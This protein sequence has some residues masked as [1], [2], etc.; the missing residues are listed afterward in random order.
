MAGKVMEQTVSLLGELDPSFQNM[1]DTAADSLADLAKQAKNGEDATKQLERSMSQMGDSTGG[2]NDGFTVMKGI[3][4]NLA[5]QAITAGIDAVKDF[6]RESI[7]AGMEFTSTMS[8][9]QAISGASASE[10]R[11]LEET[12]RMYGATTKFSA[13]EAGE[14][15]TYMAMAG[16]KTTDMTAGLGGIL[17]LA[18]AAGEDL[19]TTSDIVTDGLTAFGLSASESGHFADVM[20]AASSSAN[21]NVSMMGETFKY[22]GAVA[23]AMGISI[24][25][26]SIATGLMAN[27]GIKASSAGTTLRTGLTNL[28]KPSKQMAAAME[29]YGVEIQKNA[30]GNVDLMATMEN[31][32]GALGGLETTEQNAAIAAIFGKN[33]MS[34]WAAIVNASSDDFNNLS[35]SIYNSQGAAERMA[36]TMNDNLAGDIANFNSAVGE[37]QLSVFDKAEPLLRDITQM[38]TSIVQGLTSLINPQKSLL[39]EFITDIE[40]ANNEAK[41]LVDSAQTTLEQKDIDISKLEAAKDIILELNSQDIS[42]DPWKM[43]QMQDAV[44]KVSSSIPQIG[45][46]YDEVTGHI[47]LTEKAINDLFTTQENF[48]MQQALLSAKS[49]S[50][51][52]YAKAVLNARAASSALADAEARRTEI[53][54][55][56]DPGHAAELEADYDAAEDAVTDLTTK[57]IDAL[58]IQKEAEEQMNHVNDVFE[59]VSKE[60]GITVDEYQNADF[61]NGSVNE[62]S[63]GI[64][65]LGENAVVSADEVDDAAK[66]AQE[67]F[68]EMAGGIS[69]SIESSISAFNAFSGGTEI[70]T[71]AVLENLQSQGKGI[72]N[73]SNN[74]QTLAQADGMTQ[75]F[76]DYLAGLGTEG[77]NLVQSLTDSIGTEQFTQIAEQFSENMKLQD[78]AGVIASYTSVG[79]GIQ[80]AVTEPVEQTGENI[81]TTFQASSNTAGQSMVTEFSTAMSTVYSN[82]QS[83]LSQ[84]Q[85]LF[86]STRFSFNQSIALPHFSMSGSFDAK[87]GAV[88]SVSVS[89]YKEGGI[90]SGAQIFGMLG[91]QFLGGGE[92][93]KEAVLPLDTLW[94]RMGEIFSS[95]LAELHHNNKTQTALAGNLIGMEDFSL[96]DMAARNESITYNLGGVTFA[97]TVNVNGN[98]SGGDIMDQLR[99]QE[100]EFFDWLEAWMNRKAVAGYA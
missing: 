50:Y 41:S 4:A 87:S 59:D 92:A 82:A 30:E 6:T 88:P 2:L 14:A 64:N 45:T 42:D 31:V 20:A 56:M 75:E 69:S 54:N 32:R 71:D 17:N 55:K 1:A 43:Y 57:E 80:T 28:V 94:K 68:E 11:V 62:A 60:I 18:A 40:N 76:Y 93:G 73:W 48:I 23:G 91:D 39:D 13:N 72:E 49:E 22:A 38:G 86:A 7:E 51:E 100:S 77:A 8:E 46:A 66:K 26:A 81:Q 29:N 9:V 97:P 85:S 47:N 12:A 90:L 52:A 78:E 33:A 79:T 37:L 84:L 5:T 67:A 63:D 25:D 65:N 10:M 16:W 24:E 19:A 89:W 74:M 58:Q 83:S 53:Y 44:T 99:E 70:G 27:A 21:T 3:M 15:L 96:S 35:E 95:T 34:G 61:S 98:N 36:Q